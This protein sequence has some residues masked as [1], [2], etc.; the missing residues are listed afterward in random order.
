MF[1]DPSPRHPVQEASTQHHSKCISSTCFEMFQ[2]GDVELHM[3][4]SSVHGHCA[5]DLHSFSATSHSASP[6][7]QYAGQPPR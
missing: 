6:V 5:T 2:R 3:H 7:T 4:G 1:R